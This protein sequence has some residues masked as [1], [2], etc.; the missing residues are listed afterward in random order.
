M[1]IFKLIKLVSLF[2]RYWYSPR[3]QRCWT[4][5]RIICV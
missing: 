1:L 4:F 3:W 5:C 2:F